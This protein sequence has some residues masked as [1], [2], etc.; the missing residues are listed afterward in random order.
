MS[1]PKHNPLLRGLYFLMIIMMFIFM[2]LL[3][4]VYWPDSFEPV[5]QLNQQYDKTIENV[6]TNESLAKK[7]L[8]LHSHQ[9]LQI[10]GLQKEI[11]LTQ[12]VSRQMEQVWL[13]FSRLNWEQWLKSA[14]SSYS[15]Y[16]HYQDY[17]T[18]RQT[19]RLTIGMDLEQL[20][21][22]PQ[23]LVQ[24]RISGGEFYL[25]QSVLDTWSNPGALPLAYSNDFEVVEID[26]N[27][28]FVSQVA[29]LS[30]NK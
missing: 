21:Y 6:S 7:S 3:I 18:N 1:L 13:E 11:E 22:V 12:H 19:V 16:V 15:I 9:S 23:Q 14:S 2:S 8:T 29:Y 17:D 20:R 10:V 27:Y 25:A 4:R 26:S 5:S 24:Q 28:R 30:L